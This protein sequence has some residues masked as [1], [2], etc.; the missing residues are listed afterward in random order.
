M[1]PQE[2]GPSPSDEGSSRSPGAGGSR[3]PRPFSR[4]PVGQGGPMAKGRGAAWVVV[5]V[6]VGLIPTAA[7]ASSAPAA[8]QGQ[9]IDAAAAA[10]AAERAPTPPR[11]L[12]Q[13]PAAPA[14]PAA[15]PPTGPAAPPT[16]ASPANPPTP[17]TAE[18][19]QE[20]V[21]DRLTALAQRL[22][23]RD[24]RPDSAATG[25]APTARADDPSRTFAAPS[26]P[27]TRPNP[28]TRSCGFPSFA[29]AASASAGSGSPT[30]SSPSPATRFASPRSVW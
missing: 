1:A 12:S 30:T 18:G 23:G 26:A 19:K 25:G 4:G 7:P 21:S 5:L 11:P 16:P 17:L 20:P 8:S 2:L 28:R 15:A 6:G 3:L 9:A 22:A 27:T 29:S 24:P 14:G 10:P 13:Q